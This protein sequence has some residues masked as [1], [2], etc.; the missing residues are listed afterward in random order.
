[1][2]LNYEYIQYLLDFDLPSDSEASFCDS[3]DRNYDSDGNAGI[4]HVQNDN[5]TE[6]IENITPQHI[7][8]ILGNIIVIY[9]MN[10]MLYQIV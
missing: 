5:D 3:D 10:M 1:M 8:D 2:D 4:L 6:E 7:E 9:D